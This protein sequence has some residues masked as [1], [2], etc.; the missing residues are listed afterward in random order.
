MLVSALASSQHNLLISSEASRTKPA[1]EWRT[2][3]ELLTLTL[4]V[5]TSSGYL[6]C[7]RRAV[8]GAET[9][10]ELGSFPI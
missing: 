2:I 4:Q 5:P 7:K 8:L 6:A 9:A 1:A 10:A 3:R